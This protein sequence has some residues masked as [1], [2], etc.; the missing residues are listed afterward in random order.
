MK[1]TNTTPATAAEQKLMEKRQELADIF[2]RLDEAR[3]E[4]ELEDEDRYRHHEEDEEDD[5][6]DFDD[7]ADLRP[8]DEAEEEPFVS[9]EEEAARLRAID[10]RLAEIARGDGMEDPTLSDEEEAAY[11]ETVD[12]RLERMARETAGEI[13]DMIEEYGIDVRDG[14]TVPRL[15]EG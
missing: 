2:E 7:F 15:I 9:E 13:A 3:Y 6:E 5:L 8:I 11:M 10:E 14:Y 12:A 1:N 4:A